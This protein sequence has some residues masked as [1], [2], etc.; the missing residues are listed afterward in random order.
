MNTGLP[1]RQKQR[2]WNSRRL[3]LTFSKDKVL[4][5][6]TALANEGGG[7][8]VLGVSDKRPRTV[9]GTRAYSNESEL[10]EIKKF[11]FDKLNLRVHVE[12]VSHPD[13]RV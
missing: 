12:E 13:G 3:R 10:N 9:V 7:H 5:Y 6:S 11:L 8:L 4:N 1:P 2:N